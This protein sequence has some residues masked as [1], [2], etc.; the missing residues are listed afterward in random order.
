MRGGGTH[1]SGFSPS[2]A[3]PSGVNSASRQP[4]HFRAWQ[5][6]LMLLPGR[7]VDWDCCPPPWFPRFIADHLP[8]ALRGS[9]TEHG[10]AAQPALAPHGF[11][12]QAKEVVWKPI[13]WGRAG[14]VS[15]LLAIVSHSPHSSCAGKAPP[16]ERGHSC[17]PRPV[18][19][20]VDPWRRIPC[21][22]GAHGWRTGI[23]AL[24]FVHLLRPCRCIAEAYLS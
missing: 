4:P 21:F 13:G 20:L 9:W 12:D 18:P 22:A 8:C 24:P 1:C 17:P 2:P 5:G 6:I 11:F 16:K 7:V 19:T 14:V 15:L 3:G 23:S 10:W